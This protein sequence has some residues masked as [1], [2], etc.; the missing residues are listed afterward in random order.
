M[1]VRSGTSSK[2]APTTTLR[3]QDLGHF[4]KRSARCWK[5]S[6]NTVKWRSPIG[7]VEAYDTIILNRPP[8]DYLEKMWVEH[9]R[10]R[11]KPG[12]RLIG[13]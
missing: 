5:N 9:L 2:H 6:T 4:G 7:S 3:V 12:G 10:L 11:L 8:A 13:D 1:A